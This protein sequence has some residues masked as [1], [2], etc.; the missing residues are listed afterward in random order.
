MRKK[1]SSKIKKQRNND[2]EP[3]PLRARECRPEKRKKKY[4]IRLHEFYDNNLHTQTGS[5]KKNHLV[6]L[7]VKRLHWHNNLFSSDVFHSLVGCH[8]FELHI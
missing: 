1:Y 2:D 6:S 3:I 8:L 4:C 5:K 7:C